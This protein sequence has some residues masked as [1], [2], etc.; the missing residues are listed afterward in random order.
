MRRDLPQTGPQ[1][2]VALRREWI[3][4]WSESS[5]SEARLDALIVGPCGTEDLAGVILGALRLNL[6]TVVEDPGA[7]PL[8][9]AL[10]AAGFAPLTGDTDPRVVSRLAVQAA[11]NGGPGAGELVDG[12]S[13]AN[14][15]RAGLAVGGGP[16]SLVHLSAVAREAGEVGFPQTIRVLAPESPTF[17][18]PLGPAEAIALLGDAVHD[19]ETVGG[20]MLRAS[21][22]E[23]SGE[24]PRIGSR[25]R[26]VTGRA[27]G[28]EAVVVSP[29]ELEEVSGACRVFATEEEAVEDLSG[30][31]VEAGNFIVV[32]GCGARG[33]PGLKRLESLGTALRAANPGVPVITDGLPP[34]RPPDG[35]TWFSLFTPEATSGGVIGR[36]ADGDFLR[37][38]L[39]NGRIRTNVPA[40]ELKGRTAF[41]RPRRSRFGYA[42]RYART[43]LPAL[44]G[45]GFG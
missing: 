44:S 4:D 14:A 29:P 33:G 24:E 3:A 43:A 13:L 7:S 41:S 16:E 21:L 19:L 37:F 31:G 18:G 5:F 39:L 32:A 30:G 45:A 34:E 36:L 12:F 22:P 11:S 42:A 35:S 15:L 9:T 2:G 27:S 8:A 23:P 26:I 17:V 28:V 6:P 40:D 1:G 38:D 20:E 25:L 10:A